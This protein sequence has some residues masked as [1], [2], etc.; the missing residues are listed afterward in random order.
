MDFSARFTVRPPPTRPLHGVCAS[1]VDSKL[2]NEMRNPG[3]AGPHEGSADNLQR[4]EDGD[5]LRLVP[6]HLPKMPRVFGF[7]FKYSQ[8]FLVQRFR[9][10]CATALKASLTTKPSP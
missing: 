4:I 1:R 7:Q 6:R 9:Q 3:L 5:R 2:V 8:A 10:F